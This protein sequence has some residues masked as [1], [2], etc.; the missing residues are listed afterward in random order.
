MTGQNME[1]FE[2]LLK[3]LNEMWRVQKNKCSKGHLESIFLGT[4]ID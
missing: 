1:Y 4:D 3:K 2:G